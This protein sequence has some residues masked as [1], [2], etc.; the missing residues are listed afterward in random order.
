MLKNNTIPNLQSFIGEDR[1]FG[2]SNLYVDLIPSSCWFTNVRYC[3]RPRDWD[4]IR[5]IVYER[6][7]YKC[8]CCQIDCIK[9]KIPIEA[10][11][12][13]DYDF[14]TGTQKLVRLIGLC[15]RCHQSTH[16]GFAKI[17]GKEEE[18][19]TH[20]KKIRNFN[21]EELKEHIDTAWSIWVERNQ[22]EWKLDLSIITSNGFDI[23]KPVGKEERKQIADEK[24]YK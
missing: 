12:R 4:V 22:Y 23:I 10:H 15:K 18:A 2:G 19:S 6:T 7:D 11:E 1:N 24:L 21:L 13:W 9:E 14:T 20:I 16:F 17:C 3:V 5:K 8:E